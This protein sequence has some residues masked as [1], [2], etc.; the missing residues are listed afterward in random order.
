MTYYL[1]FPPDESSL[2]FIAASVHTSDDS[3]LNDCELGHELDDWE[4]KEWLDIGGYG[5]S[6]CSK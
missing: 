6:A 5:S 1:D 3:I 2:E 4:P